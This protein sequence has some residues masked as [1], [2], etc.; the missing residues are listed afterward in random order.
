MPELGDLSLGDPEARVYGDPGT[1]TQTHGNRQRHTL[2][3]ALNDTNTPKHTNTERH[4]NLWTYRL[5]DSSLLTVLTF[6]SLYSLQSILH[7][8]LRSDF[9]KTKNRVNSPVHNLLWLP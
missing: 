3:H 5:R 7:G 2:T 9:L 6:F 8:S 4:A 1:K